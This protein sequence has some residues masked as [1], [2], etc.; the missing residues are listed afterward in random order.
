VKHSFYIPHGS[1]ALRQGEICALNIMEEKVP[2]T[3]SQATFSANMDG[4]VLSVSGL[5]LENAKRAGYQADGIDYKNPYRGG[6]GYHLW[7]TYEKNTHKILGIQMIGT[8]RLSSS[9]VNIIS[10][11]IQQGLR[12]E[13]LELSDFYLEHGYADPRGF[14][15]ICAELIREKE[16]KNHS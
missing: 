2:M 3:A 15:K 11:A 16:V 12:I 13:D 10:L 6:E 1:D 4:L 5:T 8:Q 9:Y 14:Q 7:M